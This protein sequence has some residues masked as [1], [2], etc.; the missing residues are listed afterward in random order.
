MSSP[1]GKSQKAPIVDISDSSSQ[2]SED[3][4]LPREPPRANRVAL[5]YAAENPDKPDA[6]ANGQYGLFS[7]YSPLS[8]HLPTKTLAKRKKVSG[9]NKEMKNTSR[10]KKKKNKRPETNKMSREES[11]LFEPEESWGVQIQDDI[12]AG[13]VMLSPPSIPASESRLPMRKESRSAAVAIST[14]RSKRPSLIKTKPS[15]FFQHRRLDETLPCHD[16]AL[17]EARFHNQ[18][19]AGIPRHLPLCLSGDYSLIDEYIDVLDELAAQDAASGSRKRSIAEL[20]NEEATITLAIEGIPAEEQRHFAAIS[21]AC[22]K[23]I[24]TDMATSSIATDMSA[25]QAAIE[26]RNKEAEVSRQSVLGMMTKREEELRTQRLDV[27]CRREVAL[28]E[29][30]VTSN[31]DTLSLQEAK[32]RLEKEGGMAM[33]VELGRRIERLESA[34]AKRNSKALAKVRPYMYKDLVEMRLFGPRDFSAQA[35]TIYGMTCHVSINQ[36]HLVTTCYM[37][38]LNTFFL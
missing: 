31:L 23:G 24:Q 27:R 6:R 28:E 32:E 12:D 29:W 5:H 38:S 35:R 18:D 37:S 21:Q 3:N 33:A 20:A 30:K 36:Q 4:V 17:D 7:Q 34:E 13:A 11:P 19:T 14:S 16:S 8:S 10:L 9:S 1:H 22:A 2:A 25:I 15:S 26:T